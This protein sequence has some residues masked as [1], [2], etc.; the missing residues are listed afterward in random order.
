MNTTLHLRRLAVATAVALTLLTACGG[1]SRIDIQD[2]IVPIESRRLIADAEDAV[3]IARA[4][5]NDALRLRKEMSEWSNRVRT[6]DT[7]SWLTTDATTLL[8]QV[9]DARLDLA[10]LQV[11]HARA[12]LRLAEAKFDLVTAETAIRHDLA[13]YEL[14]P[15]RERSNSALERVRSLSGEVSGRRVEVNQLLGQWWQSYASAVRGQGKGAAF[16]NDLQPLAPPDP[17]KAEAPPTDKPAKEGDTP[18]D[19]PKEDAA[20]SAEDSK[21]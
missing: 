4:R 21:G 2:P 7:S 1:V 20:P 10:D 16:F 15:L 3:S 18:A 17:P 19:P 13:V 11:A 14:E 8:N 9:A 12:R 5:Y 6:A